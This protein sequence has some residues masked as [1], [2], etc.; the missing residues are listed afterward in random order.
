[1]GEMLEAG[2]QTGHVDAVLLRLAEHYE[3][4]LTLRRIFLV[5]ILWPAIQLVLAIFVIGL[6]IWV[7]GFVGTDI[8]GWGMM[9]APRASSS[10]SRSYRWFLAADGYSCGARFEAG[11]GPMPCCVWRIESRWCPGQ[12]ADDLRGANWPG[13]CPWREH[14]T[15]I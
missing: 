7:L 1:M 12:P 10:T 4:L 15:P 8:L 6:L 2:D 14:S 13:R 3:H 9:P 5:G 11:P